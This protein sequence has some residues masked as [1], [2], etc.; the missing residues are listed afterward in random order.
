MKIQSHDNTR[1][2]DS[3][4]SYE[5]QMFILLSMVLFFVNPYTTTQGNP[6]HQTK[7]YK[8]MLLVLKK[9]FIFY[10]TIKISSSQ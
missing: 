4:T 8:F 9:F 1:Q 3:L 5:K 2:G 7:P 6:R 10:I